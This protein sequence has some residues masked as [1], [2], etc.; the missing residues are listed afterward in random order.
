M[1]YKISLIPGDGIGPEVTNA[2]VKV[3]EATG[4]GFDWDVVEAGEK[5]MAKEKT[6]LPEYV[7]DSIKKNKVAI[8]GPITTPIGSGFRSVNVALRQILDLY[9]SIRPARSIAGE[10]T[11]YN[12]I[13]VVVVREATEGLYSGIEH[14]IGREKYGAETVNLITRP[15]SER[16]VKFAFEYAI[17]EKRKKITAVH[18]AN[19][20]KYTGGL[21][22]EVAQT[23]SKQYPQIYF[24]ERLVDNMAMQLVKKPSAYDVIVTTNLFGDILSD[25]CA[26]LAGGL[27]IAPGAIIGEKYALFEPVHGSAPKYAGQNMVNPVATILSGEMMLNYLGERK[28]ANAIWTSVY[29]TIKEKRYVTYDL[30]LP[31]YT[32]KPVL[33]STT[34]QMA[35]EIAR[36][37]KEKAAIM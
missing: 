35:D 22:Q 3:V 14:W 16:I 12:D 9:A 10:G 11:L 37:V 19:I 4:I 2:M 32:Q 8:K 6:P 24:E 34:S 31:E 18:K 15:A 36:K 30:A 13:D 17:K 21:F 5:V 20:M 23:I 29:E 25:L 27:G 28:A 26:G 33:P 7:L 1:S